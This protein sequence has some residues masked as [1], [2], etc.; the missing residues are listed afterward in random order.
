MRS[1]GDQSSALSSSAFLFSHPSAG[2]FFFFRAIRVV[3]FLLAPKDER[4]RLVP[5]SKQTERMYV[6]TA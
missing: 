4:K 3:I 2:G 1:E 5:L 6:D